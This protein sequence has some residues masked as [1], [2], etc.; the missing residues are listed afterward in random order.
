MNDFAWD[1]D[2]LALQIARHTPE[3]II[4]A[5][6]AGVILYWNGGARK[7]F[8]FTTQEA[9]GQTLDIIIPEKHRRAHWAGW[10][11]VV[12]TGKSRYQ[13]DELL[14]VPG[15]R[16][17]GTRVSLEFSIFSIADRYGDTVAIGATLRDVSH[18]FN[19][20]KELAGRLKA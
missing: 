13:A 18:H 17:D 2:K 10:E 15:L 7:L 1:A 8:G 5:D 19:K 6:R 11:A 12:R 14:A 3:A 16:K 20:I 9:L 4:I